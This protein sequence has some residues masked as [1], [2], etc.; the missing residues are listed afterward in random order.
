MLHFL[1]PEWFLALLPLVIIMW[2]LWRTEQENSTWNR[3]I[4]PHLAALLVTKTKDVKRPSLSYLAVS[5]LIAV[6]AL[7]G[8]AFTQQSLPVFE[9]TQG[10]V[11]VMDMSLSMYATDQAPNRLSQAKFKATD[12]IGELTEGE[13]GL[14][15]YA[16]DAY[17]ISPLTRDR[18]TL[19]N[20]LP[21]LSPDI[22]PSRGSNLVAALEQSKNL[23]AQG[24]H[25]GGDILLLS[26]GIPPRQLNEAK[27]V[28]KGTQ[29]RLG[30]LA[31][32]SEQGS[33]IRLPDGQLLRDNANQ[34]VVAKTNYLQL[35]ELAQETDGILI[36]FR[37]DGQDLQQLLTWLSTTGETKATELDGEIWQDAG[38]FIAL[39]LLIP[40]LLSFRHGLV[41]VALVCIIYQPTPAMASSWDDVWQTKNQQGMEA[42]QA[43][44]YQ[45]ASEKFSDPQWQ[46]SARY[47]AG[48]YDEAL[49]LFEQDE[50]ATGLYNQGNS[51]MQQGKYDE[52]IKRYERA[53][54]KNP[55]LKDA[56]ENLEL[57]KKLEE[58]K[59]KSSEQ[60]EDSGQGDPS[61][62]DEN[63]DKEKESKQEKGSDK[64][65]GSEQE[66]ESGQDENSEQSNDANQDEQSA[67]EKQA[68]DP[69]SQEKSNESEMQ[70][71]PDKKE[72]EKPEGEDAQQ[73]SDSVE[74]NGES[75]EK[76]QSKAAQAEMN[77]E[78]QE[79]STGKTTAAQQAQTQDE[80]PPEME[81]ALRALADDPQV[82]LR[83]KMQLEYQ[84]RRR[85][86]MASQ[87][88]EQW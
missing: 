77:E 46:A 79:P 14:L 13:T 35:N 63:S 12:L 62:K 80:L 32:G 16:G 4:S 45:G 37:T 21:T 15:A 33:P 23:L 41:G 52:A 47:K 67:Q 26:D 19:L 58:Q 2:L 81:R 59:Q 68:S 74:Q 66:N 60:D 85:Q 82:L 56:H 64:G 51:L 7:S 22:M 70:A 84:K 87:E 83:N 38:P 9:A 30:I 88:Q 20:L 57:A 42:Y 43:Q 61:D 3:Y 55:E 44:E 71:D 53:L 39:L 17:T 73:S 11:I 86:G 27:K 65:D 24:G 8:P 76:E 36:P 18:S 1:R 50:S 25:I 5:W 72:A 49:A 10:R 28:L 54:K 31:F 69:A 29:Y 75:A 48:D 6:F 78:A 34:V 40:V